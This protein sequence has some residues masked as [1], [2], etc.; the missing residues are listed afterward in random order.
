[1]TMS[2]MKA[3]PSATWGDDVVDEGLIEHVVG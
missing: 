1:V 3:S 2:S